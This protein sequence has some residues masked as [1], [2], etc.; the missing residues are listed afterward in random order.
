MHD[1]P[2]ALPTKNPAALPIAAASTPI[3]RLG[4]MKASSFW[5]LLCL[6]CIVVIGV[7][8][9]GAVGGSLAAG[10]KNPAETVTKTAVPR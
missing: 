7:T 4:D 5:L 8:V 9:G 2:E 10:K 6:I 1:D 3:R